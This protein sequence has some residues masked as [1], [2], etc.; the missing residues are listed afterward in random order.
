MDHLIQMTFKK[1]YVINLALNFKDKYSLSSNQK[2]D[3]QFKSCFHFA[4]HLEIKILYL[5][6]TYWGKINSNSV[7]E[8]NNGQ[9]FFLLEWS[10]M[11]NEPDWKKI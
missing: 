9:P 5:N 3:G 10:T 6:L 2:I 8:H 4:S 11:L 1:I 7:W